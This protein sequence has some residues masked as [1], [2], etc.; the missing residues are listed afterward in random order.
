[1]SDFIQIENQIINIEKIVNVE[2]GKSAVS[3]LSYLKFLL[4][5]E[6]TLTFTKE[7][8]RDIL[9]IWYKLL[10]KIQAK[11]VAE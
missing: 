6:I 9:S 10:L 4:K 8:E 1:M 11:T 5:N 7:D 2:H 3:G